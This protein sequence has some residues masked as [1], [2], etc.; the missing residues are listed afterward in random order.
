MLFV[1]LSVVLACTYAVF[2]A[3]R[4][5]PPSGAIVVRADT[6]NSG[7]YS[8]VQ[9]AVDSLPDDGSEQGIFIYPGTYTEQVDITRSGPL[10]IYGYTEDT[11]SYSGNQAVIAFNMGLD[12]AGSNDA[13]GT[14]R[15]HTND[16]KMYNVDVKNTRGAG[17]QAGALSEY[18]SRVGFYGCGF[19]GYQDTLYAND[20]T[21]VYLKGYIEGKIDFIYGRRGSAYFGGNTIAVSGPGYITASGRESDDSGSYVF[22]EN[23]V[24]QT[25]GAESG[26]SGGYY[27]GRPWDVYAK[28]IFKS[29]TLQVA[30][31]PALW[32]LWNGDS[33][34]VS[35][36]FLA[37]YKTSGTGADSLS[38]ASFAKQLSDDQARS[39]SI[40][41]AVGAD[42]ADWVDT[43]Y[44]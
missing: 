20:G 24:V 44:L 41:S 27:F 9:A 39:Y 14:L 10:T 36:A 8:S 1:S 12:T 42:Y 34:S 37:D 40:S 33:D 11:S 26:T 23:T 29:T 22:E 21:Q 13:S 19:Y 25:S 31:N 38:R 6:S 2:G 16:F 18:G 28:V 30:P 4:T 15:I 17:V 3:S 7:E 32:S 5:E 43:S 35:N